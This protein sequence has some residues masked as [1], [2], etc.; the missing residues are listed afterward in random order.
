MKVTRKDVC[1]T[2]ALA[3]LQIKEDEFPQT[4]KDLQNILSYFSKLQDLDT[5]NIF[6]FTHD[7]ETENR[8]RNDIAVNP[9][10]DTRLLENAPSK[11]KDLIKVPGIIEG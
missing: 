1:H 5:K 8:L 11:D 2:A 7:K 3:R 6:P 10:P 4:I 9:L